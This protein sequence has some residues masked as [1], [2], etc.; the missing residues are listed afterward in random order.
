MA[1]VNDANPM[2]ITMMA[3]LIMTLCQRLKALEPTKTQK[4]MTEDS[5]AV[6]VSAI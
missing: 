6:L 3:T 4:D 5:P 2:T 1:T